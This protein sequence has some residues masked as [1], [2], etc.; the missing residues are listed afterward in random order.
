M[1]EFET[2]MIKNFEEFYNLKRLAEDRKKDLIK[3]YGSSLDP[4]C[5]GIYYDRSICKWVLTYE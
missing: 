4:D 1:G 3:R 5:F 2:Y